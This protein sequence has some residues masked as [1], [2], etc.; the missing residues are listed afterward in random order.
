MTVLTDHFTLA[1]GVQIPKIGFGTWRIP[2]GKDAYDA[3][4]A[5]LESGYRHIDTARSYGNEA[6]VAEAIA[7]SGIPRPRVFV[8]TKPPGRRQVVR[9]GAEQ[10]RT[11]YRC[12][13]H[14]LRGPLPDPR[15]L[16]L[17]G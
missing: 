5:A 1:N 8:T 2:D 16:A 9:R 4:A 10:F 11:H 15:S 3:V 17:V 14:G 6:S 7:D 12:V 13:G